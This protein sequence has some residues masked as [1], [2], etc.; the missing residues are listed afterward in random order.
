MENRKVEA[1]APRLLC[2]KMNDIKIKPF[3]NDF[4]QEARKLILLGLGEHWRQINEQANPDID[5]LESSFRDG[6]FLTAWKDNQLVGVGGIKLESEGVYRIQRMSIKKDI[7]RSGIGTQVLDGLIKW[8]RK[9][10]A[11]K[12][13]LET[14]SAWK[15]A[16]KFYLE[17]GFSVISED[18]DNTH[19]ELLL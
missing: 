14:T 16:I 17:Y 5:D 10:K 11:Q 15:S 2:A 3:K 13:V 9:A 18:T 12:I 19:F 8:A 4:Q 7:R 6:F 1:R